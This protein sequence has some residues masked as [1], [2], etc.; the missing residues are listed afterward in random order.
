MSSTL[1]DA[2]QITRAHGA[3]TV[4]DRVDVHV[5]SGARLGLIGPN[6]AGKSTL[7]RIL[8][9]IEEPDGG[10]VARHGTVGYLPQTHARG[11]R[12]ARDHV[13][14]AVGVAAAD[15]ALDVATQRL[16]DGDERAIDAHTAALDRWLALGGADADARL[17]AALDE[18]GLGSA[19]R[20]R[21]L[22]ALSGGQAARVGLAVLRVAR[23]DAILLDEP[24][25]HLDADG[26]GRLGKL[27]R[28]RQGGLVIVS[29]DRALLAEHARDLLELDA[30]TGAASLFRGGWESYERERAAARRAAREAYDAAVAERARVAE[31]EAEIRRRAAAAQSRAG[32][33]RR[34]PDKHSREF[35]AA[36]ADGMAA[37]ANRMGTRAG[38][39]DLPERPWTP[40]A[41]WLALTAGVGR[42]GVRLDSARV[43]RGAWTLGPIDLQLAAGERLLLTGANGTGKSTLIAA[44]AGDVALA[45]GAR[46]T[47]PGTVIAVLGQERLALD[48]ASVTAAV[49]ALT[50]LDEAAARAGLAGFGLGAQAA[51]RPPGTLS[52][53]ERTRAELTV[54]AGRGA[55]VL[56]LDE[57]TNHLDLESLEVLERALEDWSGA[58]V[59]ATHDRVFRDR[60]R[61][62]REVAL[63]G[64]PGG[65]QRDC[66]ARPAAATAPTVSASGM[67]RQQPVT[68]TRDPRRVRRE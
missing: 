12:T 49:R 5:S 30:H 43:L 10:T 60:L 45:G 34:D 66:S 54:A 68:V 11:D 64:R 24:T 53:G 29:H 46:H 41:A 13:L 1:I 21:P 7:L 23:F 18:L 39:V 33:R 57:P 59:V 4:L 36:R 14:E 15:R 9:G 52:P 50:G 17:D 44:L 19:V 65:A 32:A 16:A 6:G 28:E 56:L 38:R 25:N 47:S 67:G 62:D 35:A 37:R 3:R 55:N 48:G 40:P 26:L 20:D 63:T 27:L 42:G 61:V 8:V 58:L 22:G 2:R 31:A 51:E